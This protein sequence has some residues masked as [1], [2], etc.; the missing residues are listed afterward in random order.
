M[1]KDSWLKDGLITGLAGAAAT[2]A[3]LAAMG[4]ARQGSAW[5]PFNAISHMLFGPKAVDVEGFAPK[6]TLSGLGLNVS[7]LGVW[8]GLY[9]K[10]AGHVEFPRSLFA[11]AAASALIWAF[12]YKVVP[13]RLRPGFEKRLGPESVLATYTLLALVLGSSPLWKSHL[14]GG[15][16]ESAK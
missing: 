1:A 6:E 2:T 7:A 11:G 5:T 12:D 3:V 4:Q 13:D 16:G 9:E 14:H 8:G 10:L 15:D